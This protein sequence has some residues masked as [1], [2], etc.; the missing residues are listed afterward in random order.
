MSTAIRL[1]VGL[2]NPG[3]DYQNTRHNVGTRWVKDLAI[4]FGIK[5]SRSRL[6]QAEKGRGRILGHDV[7]LI[8][9]TTY[10]NNSG[11][12][13]G[14]F[15]RYFKIEPAETL[16]VFD[17]VAFEPGNTRFKLGGGT[18]GH[19][20]IRSIIRHLQGNDE[21][22]RL[23]IGVGHPGDPDVMARYLTT[24]VMPS[25]ERELA[26]WSSHMDEAVLL[27]LLEGDWE[28]VMTALHSRKP[29]RD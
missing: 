19:N 29:S 25:E 26:E 14:R 22:K 23:R 5:L 27:W 1:V 17:D 3:P 20:G 7:R 2:G 6:F 28:R 12:A 8:V 16:V 15:V 4:R 18:N 10:M 24:S 13:V 21:F 9:P 11:V